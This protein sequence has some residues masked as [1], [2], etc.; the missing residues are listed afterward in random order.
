MSR[1]TVLI[2]DD[3]PDNRA[4]IEEILADEGYTVLAAESAP[5]ARSLARR[6]PVDL[7]LLDIWMPG[8][9]GLSLLK[10]WRLSG[11]A[12]FPVLMMSGHGTIDTAIEAT[13]L[14]AW[15]YLEKPFAMDK[16]L[17]S[18]SRALETHRLRQ[19]NQRLVRDAA[20]LERLVGSDPGVQALRARIEALAPGDAP[21][22]IVGEDGCE[23]LAAA[24]ALHRASARHAQPFV[25]SAQ[26]DAERLFNGDDERPCLL[27]E[28]HGGTLFLEP[29]DRLPATAQKRLLSV[30]RNRRLLGADGDVAPL[31]VRLVAALHR[32]PEEAAADGAL[33][34]GL[35]ELLGA[36]PLRL[37]PLRERAKDIPELV[38]HFVN[39]YCNEEGLGW[40]DFPTAV[41]N[42]LI[43]QPWPG[44]VRELRQRV[45]QLLIAGGETEVSPLE[46][47]RLLRP[48]APAGEAE[49]TGALERLVALPFRQARAHFER[50]YYRHH[51][52]QCGGNMRRLADNTGME[53][54]Y[55][56]RKLK[57]LDLRRPPLDGD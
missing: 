45:Y 5:R 55:L 12:A 7:A 43:H 31:D 11:D 1:E 48:P 50:A 23:H 54:T 15:H 4:Q 10:S 18:V 51:L 42:T 25:R 9:D 38:R 16:L 17:L 57:E 2:V 24:A 47:E 30:L 46:L 33:E 22:L 28:A 32:P 20:R 49:P 3:E 29:L 13:R 27:R 41:M 52:D 37:P 56:Y 35:R 39:H 14:G 8:E 44:N 6:H 19:R 21:A 53:R 36:E 34:P 40:R 26:P